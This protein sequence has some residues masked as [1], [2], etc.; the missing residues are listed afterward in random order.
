M[1]SKYTQ[2]QVEARRSFTFS[3]ST[4]AYVHVRAERS[5]LDERE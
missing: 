5:R 3:V 4:H 1:Q 2:Q